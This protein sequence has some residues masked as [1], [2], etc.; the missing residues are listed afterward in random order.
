MD[1][2]SYLFLKV[3]KRTRACK[4]K[5]LNYLYLRVRFLLSCLTWF[6]SMILMIASV[7]IRDTISSDL[8]LQS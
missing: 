8:F 6:L 2:I 5:F 7:I 1:A 4:H 3:R